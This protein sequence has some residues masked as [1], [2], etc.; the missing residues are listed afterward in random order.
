MSKTTGT[1]KIDNWI[2]EGR[3]PE[4]GSNYKPSCALETK[5][6]KKVKPFLEEYISKMQKNI[7]NRTN[8]LPSKN[9][10]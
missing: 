4:V 9:N 7:G 5:N 10:I 3:G 8:T 1:S 6:F 2:K